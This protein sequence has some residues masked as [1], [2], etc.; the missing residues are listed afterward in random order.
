ML[1]FRLLAFVTDQVIK[2]GLQVGVVKLFMAFNAVVDRKGMGGFR[3]DN[4][5]RDIFQRNLRLSGIFFDKEA[6]A[7]VLEARSGYLDDVLIG[8][9]GSRRREL[10]KLMIYSACAW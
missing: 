6:S 5:N 1:L 4:L 8:G 2:V 10:G 9:G 7:T 3:V